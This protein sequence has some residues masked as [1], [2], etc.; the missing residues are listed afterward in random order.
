MK[1]EIL[2]PECMKGHLLKD[3]TTMRG[4]CDSCATE[5]IFT[6]TNQFKYAP[7]TYPIAK[8]GKNG[9]VRRD[10]SRCSINDFGARMRYQVNRQAPSDE[11]IKR[12][13]QLPLQPVTMPNADDGSIYT[14]LTVGED[15]YGR[16]M[17]DQ[18]SDTRRMQTMGEFYEDS[19]VD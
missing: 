12:I 10:G 8:P 3:E 11:E 13:R 19:D 17:Y 7:P 14:W 16:D 1:T 2:C 9:G 18:K 4:V 5:F 6:G 15:K